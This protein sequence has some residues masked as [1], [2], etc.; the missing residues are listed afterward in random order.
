MAPLAKEQVRETQ[1]EKAIAAGKA[2]E[3]SQNIDVAGYYDAASQKVVIELASGA[4]YRFSVRLGKGL[5]NA[6]KTELSNIEISPLGLGIHCPAIDIGF[7]IPHL[8]E[9]IYGSKQWMS[10]LVVNSTQG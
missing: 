1:I 2:D 9:G 3:T 5:E 6:S 8:I 10:S 7:S 4:E